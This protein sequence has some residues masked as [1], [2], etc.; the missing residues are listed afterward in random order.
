M[1]LQKI[2][3]FD[4]NFFLQKFIKFLEHFLKNRKFD[5]KNYIN[6]AKI[7]N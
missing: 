1:K 6:F 3:F 2:E 5:T 7:R 4:I